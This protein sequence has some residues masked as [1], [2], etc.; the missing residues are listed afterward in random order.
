MVLYLV[1]F[2]ALAHFYDIKLYPW[3]ISAL[4]VTLLYTTTNLRYGRWPGRV[5]NTCGRAREPKG[6]EVEK[7]NTLGREEEWASVQKWIRGQPSSNN[8]NNEMNEKRSGQRIPTKHTWKEK[9]LQYWTVLA[10]KATQTKKYFLNKKNNR[11]SSWQHQK[12]AQH[13]QQGPE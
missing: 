3:I 6:G 4:L 7:A 2:M 12:E 13:Q 9:I 11:A 8:K 1:L 5:W 10:E